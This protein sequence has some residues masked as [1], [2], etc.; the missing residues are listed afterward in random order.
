M[1]KVYL[2]ESAQPNAFAT[3]RNPANAAVAATT[4]LLQRLNRDE[5]RGVLAHELGHVKHRDSLTMT[6]TAVLA[7]AIGMLAQSL[8]LVRRIWI[9][10]SQFAARRH[11]CVAD[12]AAG[13]D[14]R[15]AGA[16]RDLARPRI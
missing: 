14:R 15:D 1:P 13:A 10:G 9:A 2:I 3:G 7:G 16:A 4:G 11:W 5:L 8:F 6:L 12:D